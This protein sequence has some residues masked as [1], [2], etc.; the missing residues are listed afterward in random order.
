[1]N[2]KNFYCIFKNDNGTDVFPIERYGDMKELVQEQIRATETEP[3]E[4]DAF[5]MIIENGIP[6]YIEAFYL[7]DDE[8]EGW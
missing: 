7:D 2:S 6:T 1:M 3:N 4:W 8:E 5:F